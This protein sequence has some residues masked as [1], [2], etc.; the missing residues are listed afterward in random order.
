MRLILRHLFLDNVAASASLAGAHSKGFTR[1]AWHSGMDA[2]LT[3]EYST[4]N[5]QKFNG[6]M[7]SLQKRLAPVFQGFLDLV[8]ELMGDGAV[9]HT[10]VVA[11]CYVAHGADGDGVVDDDGPFFDGAEAENADVGLADDRQA[12]E[13]TE[14]AGIGDGESAFLNFF[15]FELLG[16]CALG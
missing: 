6:K 9:D 3:E 2:S 5:Y 8:Q 14:Y 12:E 11:E 10:M 13:S 7:A 4:R 15:G 1:G 16:A